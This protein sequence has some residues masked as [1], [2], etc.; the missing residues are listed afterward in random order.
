MSVWGASGRGGC[1]KSRARH[2]F[3]LFSNSCAP[4]RCAWGVVE[5]GAWRSWR[6]F[7]KEVSE[8][9]EDDEFLHHG[10][11]TY[12]VQSDCRTP[13]PR[14][15]QRARSRVGPPEAAGVHSPRS[16]PLV[17]HVETA[18]DK[19]TL[20]FRQTHTKLEVHRY[21]NPF[22]QIPSPQKSQNLS[23]MWEQV[24]LHKMNPADSRP[25]ALLPIFFPT[26]FRR[27]IAAAILP[28]AT[29]PPLFSSK[30][31][32]TFVRIAPD[33]T[34]FSIALDV[35]LRAIDA[36]ES[37]LSICKSMKVEQEKD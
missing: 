26:E 11:R 3:S 12:R 35:S 23:Q 34:S 25:P 13:A 16:H 21:T 9:G 19:S 37:S 20:F 36:G 24:H 32:F 33:S 17:N 29:A 5:E 15:L 30:L 22:G 10:I 8:P 4:W 31:R 7:G 27:N 18:S 14:M 6:A 28:T 1:L 2:T